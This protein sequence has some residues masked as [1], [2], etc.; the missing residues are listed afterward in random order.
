MI[1]FDPKGS[2]VDF[3]N[4]NSRKSRAI[5]NLA[6]GSQEGLRLRDAGSFSMNLKIQGQVSV[7]RKLINEMHNILSFSQVPDDHLKQLADFL[8]RMSELALMANDTSKSCFDT[9]NYNSKFMD[10]VG[11]FDVAQNETINVVKFFGTG[12]AE[13]NIELLNFRKEHWIAAINNLIKR[14]Y[15]WIAFF[16]DSWDLEI[17]ANGAT[18][19]S[20]AF[21]RT[22]WFTPNYE[23]EVKTYS[24]DLKDLIALYTLS[25]SVADTL[26]GHEMIHLPN[27]QNTV[28]DDQ[29][30]G[31]PRCNLFW[32]VE[33]LSN[34]EDERGKT[35]VHELVFT[36]TEAG[37][38][39]GREYEG[40]SK[41]TTGTV[42]D[43]PTY[44]TGFNSQLTYE[45]EE[46]S[47]PITMFITGEGDESI[48]YP[49]STISCGDTSTYN[50]KNARSATQ[51]KAHIDAL[52]DSV[53]NLKITTGS[54]LGVTQDSINLHSRRNSYLQKS[55]SI[56]Q[57]TDFTK[58]IAESARTEFFCK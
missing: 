50:I 47:E 58:E 29:M 17:E 12:T 48:L 31:G 23:S 54:T 45:E 51:T 9:L 25:N 5:S 15:S 22:S 46:S 35:F 32:F 18:G 19:G 34:F 1:N 53:A 49:V 40:L 39:H 13:E 52:L 10:L 16:S 3:A 8:K 28:T 26:M 6:S 21:I 33:G 36:D 38:S 4:A 14:V 42:R 37:S 11:Q 55:I 30:G 57:Y 2:F 20:V 27:A 43:G 56:T 7:E 41:S 24:T 44:L